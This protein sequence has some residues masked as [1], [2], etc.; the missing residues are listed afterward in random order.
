[1]VLACDDSLHPARI[2]GFIALRSCGLHGR[3]TTCIERFFLKGSQVGIETHF[4]AEG[5]QFKYKVAFGKS[6]N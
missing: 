1:M 4:A 2:F 3:S 5:I 6:T